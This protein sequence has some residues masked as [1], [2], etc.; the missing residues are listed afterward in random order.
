MTV[1]SGHLSAII[2]YC[3]DAAVPWRLTNVRSRLVQAFWLAVALS[4]PT[5]WTQERPTDVRN[6]DFKDFDYPWVHPSGWPDHLQWMSLRLKQQVHLAHG[7]WDERDEAEKKENVSFSGLTL[8][9]VQYAHLSSDATDDAMSVLRYDSGGTQNHY[10]IY[11]YA[12]RERRAKAARLLPRRR[13]RPLW[14]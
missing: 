13:Q 3:A 8:E 9:E 1:C 2:G 5:A 7:Q 4:C 6:L 12:P 10:W 11:I 14:S